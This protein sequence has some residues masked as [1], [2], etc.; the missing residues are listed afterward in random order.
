MFSSAFE[1]V[2]H[3]LEDVQEYVEGLDPDNIVTS[4]HKFDGEVPFESVEDFVN[5]LRQISLSHG[6][7][8]RTKAPPIQMLDGVGFGANRKPKN[9]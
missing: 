1:R 2:N 8:P 4:L 6:A 7:N 5:T 9:R 3:S